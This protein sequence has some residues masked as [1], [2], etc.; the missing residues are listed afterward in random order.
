[1]ARHDQILI[2]YI[3]GQIILFAEAAMQIL[4]E[5]STR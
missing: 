3:N 1:M 4:G 5:R 2:Q